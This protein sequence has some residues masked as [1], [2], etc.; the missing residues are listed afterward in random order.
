MQESILRFF[1]SIQNPFLDKFFTYV[2]M[3]G[4]QYFIILIVA[5]IYW[6]YS[7]K[8]GFI[9][10]F[11][12]LVSTMVN[13]LMKII[14]HTVRP[15]NQLENFHAQRV[16][17]ATG[18]SFPSGHTQG[19]A[20]LFM[21]LAL[22]FQKRN[23]MVWAVILSLLV[24]VSRMYLGV[25]W[26]VDVLGGFVFASVV[27]FL[28]YRFMHKLYDNRAAFFRF[29]VLM[30]ALFYFILLILIALDAFYLDTPIELKAFY[31]IV[32]VT[33]GAA[34]GFMFE[35]KKFPFSNAATRLKKYLRFVIGIAVTVGLLTGL[36]YIFP[37]TSLATLI[38]YFI[39]GAWISGIYPI[40]GQKLMLFEKA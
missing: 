27:V 37:D 34:V 23:Y 6:N 14:F 7:K 13:S 40:L 1:Q 9:L 11:L 32:G 4:E 5:W 24:A 8:E 38:R 2:T 19:A 29:I 3:L 36:K 33:T 30:L 15:F 28:M 10:T 16:H 22:I 25:H 20:T 31:R 35:E 12:F 26:P 39:V 18:Y 21:S 17:T